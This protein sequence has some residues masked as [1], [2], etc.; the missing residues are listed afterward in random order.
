MA[1]GEPNFARVLCMALEKRGCEVQVATD[2]LEAVTR[3]RDRSY[4]LAIVDAALPVLDG[5][6]VMTLC[7]D[8]RP[9]V[10]V[11]IT[12]SYDAPGLRQQATDAGAYAFVVKPSDGARLA[13]L[14]EQAVGIRARRKAVNR[15]PVHTLR[16]L[17]PGQA[18]VIEVDGA[19]YAGSFLERHS[20]FLVLS[21][22][23]SHRGPASLPIGARLTIGFGLPDGWY[24]F[25]TRVVGQE[26][27][28]KPAALLVQPPQSV[29]HRQRRRHTR[30]AAV[31][32]V[33]YA[34]VRAGARPG[35]A[36][37]AD[38]GFGGISLVLGRQLKP[39]T[40]VAVSL[41]SKAGDDGLDFSGEVVW[42]QRQ[43]RRW[44]TGIKFFAAGGGLTAQR[45]RLF[46]A[47]Q[48]YRTR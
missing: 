47:L 18:I 20:R 2:G 15:S 39:G 9:K 48:S 32:P 5:L 21:G 46:S 42:T 1:D 14:A 40:P 30:V 43:A 8:L 34:P 29:S 13:W 36:R 38:I 22:P 19:H 33:T 6:Q 17:M 16:R 3:V 44:R 4:D 26:L 45:A 25:S 35:R 31:L 27:H 23:R 12:S 28:R 37:S 11:I 7:A 24:T 10:P 41:R